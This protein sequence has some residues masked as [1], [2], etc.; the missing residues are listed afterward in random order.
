MAGHPDPFLLLS[1]RRALTS[2]DAALLPV[3]FDAAV[4]DKYR[5]APGYELIRTNTAGRIKRQGGWTLDVGIAE[6]T[7]HAT[8]GDLLLALPA[9]EREHWLQ[10]VV[11]LPMSR[12]FL[13]MR[14]S[15]APC[16][17]DGEVRPWE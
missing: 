9:E 10:H 4:V 17:D 1:Y 12:T 3:S 15:P 2:G 8:F 13:Q 14:L 11:A 5:G 7:V 6:G 16:I